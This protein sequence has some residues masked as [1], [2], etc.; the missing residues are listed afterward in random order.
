MDFMHNTVY[1]DEPIIANLQEN[2]LRIKKIC[3]YSSDLLVNEINV[4]G[5]NVALLCCEGMVSSSILTELILLP[6]TSINLNE[7]SPQ[8]LY[9][10][11]NT[12]MLLSTDRISL[13]TYGNLFRTLNS[14]F[15]ILLI[16]GLDKAFAFGVQGYDK[17]G[18][19]E[20][21]GEGNIM[22]AH[23][24]FVEVVRTNMSLI[25]RRIKSPTLKLELMMT[26]SKSKTDIC[27]C[28][29]R[30][31]VPEKLLNDIKKSLNKIDL[32][33]ILSSGYVKPFVENKSNGFFDAVGTTERPDV[34]C[35]KLMEG[36]VAILVDGTPF[37][38]VIPKLFNESFQTLDDY[39][40]KPYYATFIRW[41]KYIAFFIS[42]LLPALYIASSIHHPELLNSTLLLILAEAES[43]A[44]FSIIAEAIGMLI[45]YEII[46]EAGIRLPKA[47]GG[48]V[49]IVA[50]L[51]IGDAAV[52]SGFVS[53]PLLTVIA[54]SVISGFL[55]P[56]LHQQTTILRILFVLFGGLWGLFGI[57]L[58]AAVFLFN[59]CS[60]ED[61]GF[62]VTAPISPF[63]PKA[64]RDIVTRINFRKMQSDTFTIESLKSEKQN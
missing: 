11:I 53:T 48:A 9:D 28:Y 49:S 20:P 30:D 62:P 31:R 42:V 58:L 6:L 55:T 5:V 51:I 17:R 27:L 52:K 12:Q 23:E 59:I 56:D 60:T 8:N 21:T 4:S 43:N 39:D 61:Y 7:S 46:R 64:M 16:D 40:F 47:V 3:D 22:G 36:R 19:S 45:A 57:S 35:S 10:H 41:I 24:G 18:I 1:E 34:L 13:F 63:T 15:A 25:R 2:I 44:P 14:G 33:V 37:A 29:M 38:L 50:G 26:G 54:I 32:E